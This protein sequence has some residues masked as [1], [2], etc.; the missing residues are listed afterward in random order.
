MMTRDR[1]KP[2]AD[3]RS[4]EERAADEDRAIAP[5]IRLKPGAG[6]GAA[7]IDDAVAP[8]HRSTDGDEP[9]PPVIGLAITETVV[10]FRCVL[11]VAG[12]VDIATAPSL[13]AA[14]QAASASCEREIWIDLTGVTFMD[15]SG[16]HA[17]LAVSD[18]VRHDGRRLAVIAP[19][20]SVR[21][22][23]ELTGV[24]RILGVVADRTSAHRLS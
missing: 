4:E 23:L 11:N 9:C 3:R 6:H 13:T 20:G 24:D 22:L 18:Q 7:P 5:I 14:L 8:D 17:L 21:R 15:L 1:D 16:V 12:E 2:Q 19:G 10:G